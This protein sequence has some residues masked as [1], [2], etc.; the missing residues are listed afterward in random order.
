MLCFRGISNHFIHMKS[1]ESATELAT[2]GW[3]ERSPREPQ[4]SNKDLDGKIPSAPEKARIQSVLGS[5]LL[6]LL[7]LRNGTT[8]ILIISSSMTG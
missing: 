3:S 4:S 6:G 1:R 7:T 8:D 5:K 2:L